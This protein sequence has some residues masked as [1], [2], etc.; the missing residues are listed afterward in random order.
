MI[1][2]SAGHGFYTPDVVNAPG[3]I[4]SGIRFLP[5][6]SGHGGEVPGSVWEHIGG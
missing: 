1:R 5:F 6:A 4:A 2:R 3:R